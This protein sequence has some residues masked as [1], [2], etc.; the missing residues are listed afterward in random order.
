MAKLQL[1]DDVEDDF[2]LIFFNEGEVPSNSQS[3]RAST[4]GQRSRVF[5]KVDELLKNDID[6]ASQKIELRRAIDFP[7]YDACP[8][9]C[10]CGGARHLNLKDGIVE[11]AWVFKLADDD[12]V[13]LILHGHTFLPWHER[14]QANVISLRFDA[15]SRRAWL[16]RCT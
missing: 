16:K 5:R 6:V 3:T 7:Y 4:P 9:H 13:R 1:T 11:R 8:K 2:S 15:K 10:P 14:A 12:S